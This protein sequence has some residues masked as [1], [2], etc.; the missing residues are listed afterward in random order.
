MMHAVTTIV[1]LTVVAISIRQLFRRAVEQEVQR[2]VA[3]WSRQEKFSESSSRLDTAAWNL[4]QVTVS[5]KDLDESVEFYENLLGFRL[6]VRDDDVKYARFE[7]YDS[8][9][10]STFSLHD[11]KNP[12]SASA[13]VYFEAPSEFALRERVKELKLKGVQVADV[14]ERPWMWTEASLRDPAGNEIILYHSGENRRY[15]P[16]R[17][18]SAT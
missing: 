4:N 10:A 7:C 11:A 12:S 6:I 17:L 8:D 16:W 18:S 15:P 13:V 2:R 9:A 5:C 14:V 3:A 1:S